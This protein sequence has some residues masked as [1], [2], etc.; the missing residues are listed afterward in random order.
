VEVLDKFF[1]LHLMVVCFITFVASKIV[2][3]GKISKITKT[4]K[5]RKG[6]KKLAPSGPHLCPLGTSLAKAGFGWAG[7][8]LAGVWRLLV[9]HTDYTGLPS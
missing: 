6:K 2:K 8:G 1:L 9:Q 4:C 5:G 3:Q 7:Q